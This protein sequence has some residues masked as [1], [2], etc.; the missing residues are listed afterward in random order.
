VA[1]VTAVAATVAIVVVVV[2]NAQTLEEFHSP[3]SIQIYFKTLL[4]EFRT[5]HF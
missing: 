3:S 2:P 5:A 4:S 1:V